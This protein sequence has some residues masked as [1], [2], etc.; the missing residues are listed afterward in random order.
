MELAK[1]KL[2]ASTQQWPDDTDAL[3]ALST[4]GVATR[5]GA[6]ALLAAERAYKASPKNEDALA[7]LAFVADGMG[8]NDAALRALNE[9]LISNPSSQEFRL[10]RMVSMVAAN[11]WEQAELDCRELLHTNPLQPTA[12]LIHGLCLYGSGEKAAGR[13]EVDIAMNLATSQQQRASIKA[14]FDRFVA[15]QAKAE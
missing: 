9:L 6:A 8:K 7:Q 12:R 14:W 15:W 4:V 13:R 1:E 3:L 10:K 5:D 11:N 2:A